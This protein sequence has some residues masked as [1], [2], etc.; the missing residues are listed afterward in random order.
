MSPDHPT[1]TRLPLLLGQFP[2]AHRP[3]TTLYAA[4]F[5]RPGH[6]L[7]IAVRHASKLG[8]DRESSNIWCHLT[9]PSTHDHDQWGG[10]TSPHDHDQWGRLTSPHDHDQLAST[11]FATM[12]TLGLVLKSS[13]MSCGMHSPLY[14]AI[15][16][17]IVVCVPKSHHA[18]L[19]W[20][21]SIAEINILVMVMGG[22]LTWYFLNDGHGHG[23]EVNLP[24]DTV[25]VTWGLA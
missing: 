9:P 25:S 16:Y 4:C 7:L 19:S 5:S 10:L 23:G 20:G 1:L 8:R 6:E 24:V 14:R 11:T 22:R 13:Y 21:Q 2:S 15:R 18:K 3:S 17:P 12:V